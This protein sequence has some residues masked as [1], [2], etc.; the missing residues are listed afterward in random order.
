MGETWQW[1]RTITPVETIKSQHLE[2]YTIRLSENGRVEA[3]FDCNLGGGGYEISPGKLSFGPLM[4]TRVAC[5]P[6][7]QDSLFMRDLQRVVS[8][9]VWDGNLYLELP[10]DSGTMRFR[11]ASKQPPIFRYSTLAPV[12]TNPPEG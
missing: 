3:R 7:S 9:F 5:P 11:P 6:D 2:R 1:E 4:S 12:L 10:F 8:F